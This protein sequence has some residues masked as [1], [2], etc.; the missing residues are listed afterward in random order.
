MGKPWGQNE[1][2]KKH[3]IESRSPVEFA[4]LVDIL[5]TGKPQQLL[6]QFGDPNF[7]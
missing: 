5:N 7:P 4:F 6:P 1:P 3:V 2:W